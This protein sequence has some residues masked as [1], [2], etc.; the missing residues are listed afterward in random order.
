MDESGEKLSFRKVTKRRPE[1]RKREESP[2]KT[3]SDEEKNNSN[4]GTSDSSDGGKV[5]K[6]TKSISAIKRL[7]RNPF[8][9]TV[10]C[11]LSSLY[12]ILLY[13]L[14]SAKTKLP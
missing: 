6:P 13:F 2:I 7:K 3:E 14:V 10:S 9:V 1:M 4:G 8:V 11:D 5:V 12:F